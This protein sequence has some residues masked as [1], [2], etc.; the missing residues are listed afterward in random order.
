[1]ALTDNIVAYWTLDE[2]SG[3]RN[4][5]VGSNHLTDVNSTPSGTGKI[6]N[7]AD[8]NGSNQH[9]DGANPCASRGAFSVSAWL[10]NDTLSGNDAWFADW[11]GSNNC[12]LLRTSGSSIQFFTTT[13]AGQAGGTV[14]S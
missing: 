8:F 1:M 6:N 10:K 12:V 9:L 5:S 3:T 4:D 13:G 11:D 2:A 14:T 7:G